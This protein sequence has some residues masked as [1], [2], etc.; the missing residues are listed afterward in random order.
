LIKSLSLTLLKTNLNDEIMATKMNQLIYVVEDNQVYNK[1]I[2]EYLKKQQYTNV[3]PFFSGEDCV[4][5]IEKGETPEIIIQDYFLENMNGLDVLRKVKKLN[6]EPEF[7]FLTNNESMEVAVNT[8]KYGAYDYI[9]KDNITLDKV[10]DRIGKITQL[11]SLERRNRL[12]QKYMMFST[13][14]IFLIIIF[15]ILYFVVDIFGVH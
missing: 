14:V 15:S 8:I 7:V 1:L 12:I 3:K 6:P 5:S 11:K 4:K 9:I 10:I 2:T 13:V